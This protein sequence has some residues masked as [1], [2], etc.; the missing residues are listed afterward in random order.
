MN[1]CVERVKRENVE[2]QKKLEESEN[3]VREL[4]VKLK[5]CEAAS[6]ASTEAW[7]NAVEKVAKVSKPVNN[8]INILNLAPL[9]IDKVISNLSDMKLTKGH[10]ID[11]QMG[12]ARAIV[13]CLT[14][15]DGKLMM[16]CSD[17]S[18]GVFYVL[19]KDGKTMKDY[20][21]RNLATVI[22]PVAVAKAKEI[23]LE[24]NNRYFNSPSLE[25]LKD[26]LEE[27]KELLRESQRD[28]E[29]HFVGSDLYDS[30]ISEI[31]EH[32]SL[33]RE[34]ES[35]IERYSTNNHDFCGLEEV[36][37]VSSGFYEIEN[38]SKVEDPK[39]SK[40]SVALSKCLS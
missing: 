22:Q 32:E 11:G 31:K 28:L 8:N 15:E 26:R 5:M 33:I 4:E 20:K 18:R 27:E 21:A 36:K 38:L 12:I 39:K 30:T 34:L 14:D 2:L 16:K 24:V 1:N 23:Y 13:P 7:E 25:G 19:D 3:T 37:L 35:K 29:S 9:D 17:P 10:V 6:L 40:F